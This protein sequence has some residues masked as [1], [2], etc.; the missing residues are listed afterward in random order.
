MKTLKTK[1][2]LVLVTVFAFSL[3]I[4]A[5][6]EAQWIKEFQGYTMAE[7]DIDTA[8]KIKKLV[9]VQNKGS[10]EEA[11]R[12]NLEDIANLIEKN[13]GNAAIFVTH[14]RPRGNP[15]LV[16][17][18][19]VVVRYLNAEEIKKRAEKAKEPP[20]L[21]KESPLDP[22]P[23]LIEYDDVKF[24]YKVLGIL[25]VR[26]DVT[27]RNLSQQ[28]MDY[29][30]AESAAREDA[31]AVIFVDYLR[32]GS[33]VSGATGVMVKGYDTWETV[34]EIKKKEAEIMRQRMKRAQEEAEK[35]AAEE[36]EQVE[37]KGT[38]E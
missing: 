34:E 33:D 20:V 27:A 22:E 35:K 26:P 10:R 36:A 13:D 30:L 8:Y 24:P 2:M 18:D 12:E 15:D 5:Q 11:E 1:L 21:K 16:M 17:T 31:T 6:L 9:S 38:T 19:A 14:M 4:P 29:K 3:L 32:A 23:V 25:N 28:A 7:N 37:E